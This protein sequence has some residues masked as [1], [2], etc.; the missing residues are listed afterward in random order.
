MEVI[1][2]MHLLDLFGGVPALGPRPCNGK[3]DYGILLDG[4]GNQATEVLTAEM[5]L[6]M[7][8]TT[9]EYCDLQMATKQQGL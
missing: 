2:H 9:I 6:V 4:H 8:G 5:D 3:N 1:E 7:A